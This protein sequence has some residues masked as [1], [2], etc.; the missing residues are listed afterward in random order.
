MLGQEM[1]NE[2]HAQLVSAQ[3]TNIPLQHNYYFTT[4]I[5]HLHRGNE[6]YQMVLGNFFFFWNFCDDNHYCIIYHVYHPSL[7]LSK[8]NIIMQIISIKGTT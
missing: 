8:R 6:V 7:L 1:T 5:I 3:S 4:K 2:T